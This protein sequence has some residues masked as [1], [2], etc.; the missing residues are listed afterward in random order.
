[1]GF[2]FPVKTIWCPCHYEYADLWCQNQGGREARER[3]DKGN[4]SISD[5]SLWKSRPE[6]SGHL[7]KL[8]SSCSSKLHWGS[9]AIHL[10]I[11]AKQFLKPGYLPILRYLKSLVM[12]TSSE[13][14]LISS[15]RTS[16]FNLYT[17]M[18]T[19]DHMCTSIYCFVSSF[20][21]QETALL[22]LTFWLAWWTNKATV[23]NTSAYQHILLVSC[24]NTIKSINIIF[25]K[26]S[27]KAKIF[28]LRMLLLQFLCLF[29]L[30]F[31]E[32]NF[33]AYG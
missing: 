6:R 28:Q 20:L 10:L 2:Q 17:T 3:E 27:V 4:V 32:F 7:L 29:S 22:G 13:F 30:F 23:L 1:M 9:L 5:P 18:E 15:T 25:V 26:F 31:W 33:R 11:D 12:L 8:H 21:S 24:L 16:W 19:I 14:S